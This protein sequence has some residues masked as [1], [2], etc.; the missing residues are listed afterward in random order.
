MEINRWIAMLLAVSRLLGML[1]GCAFD[2]LG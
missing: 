2:G 1:T